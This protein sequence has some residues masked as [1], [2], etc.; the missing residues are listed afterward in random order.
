MIVSKLRLP[1]K[2]RDAAQFVPRQDAQR[3]WKRYLS[4]NTVRIHFVI[5]FSLAVTAASALADTVTVLGKSLQ[6]L[7]PDG[8]CTLGA[9]PVERELEQFRRQSAAPVGELVQLAVPCAEL[10]AFKARMTDNFTRWVL[11]LVVKQKGQ[12]RLVTMPRLQFVRSVA[13]RLA[14]RPPDMNALAERIRDHLAKTGSS[15]SDPSVQPLGATSDA[16]FMEMQMT[17][18]SGAGKS[19]VVAV[20]AITV[21]NQLPLAVYAYATPKAR[22]ESPGNTVWSYLQKALELN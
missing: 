7:P 19:P 22:G 12:L 3:S 10:P 8:F 15:V 21:V 9:S 5:G 16:A 11:I 6:L 2:T 20:M 4:R 14:E 17:V 13:G 1:S 18:G